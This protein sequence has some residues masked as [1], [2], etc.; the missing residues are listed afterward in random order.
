MT[1]APTFVTVELRRA[2]PYRIPLA[3][4]VAFAALCAALYRLDLH[5]FHVIHGSVVPTPTMVFIAR[6]LADGPLLVT[7]LVVLLML[8]LT[9]MGLRTYALKIIVFVAIA[10][11][12]DALI[13]L[14]WD[15]PRPF[16]AGIAQAW[17]AHA[18]TAS[19]P[20]DHL[21][22]QWVAAGILWLKQ[23]TRGWG[24]AL[25]LL[26]LPMAWSRV[27]LGVHYP[28]DMLGA[29][30]IGLLAMGCAWTIDRRAS[31]ESRPV[32]TVALQDASR[33]V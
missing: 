9:R 12:L 19:F 8:V 16:A 24:V 18:T 27:Y 29:L 10:L 1:G 6:C 21:T 2:R 11:L 4:N 26:G 7:V 14:A 17:I 22:V 23:R 3:V 33:V 30:A 13:G 15:R 5:L 20:S 28:G 25:A 32:T 31:R